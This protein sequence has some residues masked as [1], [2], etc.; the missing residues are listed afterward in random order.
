MRRLVQLL[1]ALAL[2]VTSLPLGGVTPAAAEDFSIQGG[3][4][5]TQTGGG[6]GKG[7]AITDE[8][9]VRFWSEFR[10]LGGV[11]AVGYPISR[12]FQWDGFTVQ[13]MQ[14]VVFQWR[15]E[16]GQVYFINTFDLLS[17]AGKDEWLT[18]V[19]QTPPPLPADFDA[20]KDWP[21][22]VAARLALLDENP[23]IRQKYFSVVGDAVTMNG[24]PT[25][26]VT[27]MGNNLTLRAQRVVFQQWKEHVPWARAGEVTVALGGSIAAEAG[28]LPQD[29]LAAE[30]APP[31]LSG[32][33][34]L[35]A[36]PAPPPSNVQL[37]GLGY[38]MQVD[39]NADY[40]R[41]LGLTRQAGFGWV[42]VQARWEDLEAQP[43]NV[44][45]EFF[46]RIIGGA[47]AAGVKL[48]LSV[49]TA[50]M[51]SRPPGSDHNVPGPPA[52]PQ[53]FANFVGGIAARYPG[54]VGGYEIWNEQNLAREWGGNGRQNAAEYVRMLQASYRAI[55]AV[56][57]AAAVV[58]GAL[59]PAGNVNLGEG[60]LAVDDVE[61]F[62]QMYDAGMK[63]Y[64]DAV[65]AHPSG[66][67]NAPDLNPLDPAVLARPGSFRS[68]RSFYFRNFE[69]YREIM[70]RWGDGNKQIWIT[71]FGWAAG[72]NPA[73]EYAYA[74][75]NSEE[76]QANYL[77][78]AFQIARE[79]GYIG[80]MFVWN[81]NFAPGAD[82][83]DVQGKRVFGILN[84][85]WSPRAAYH[86]LAAMPK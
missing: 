8:G 61:Y 23:A 48:L 73:P 71:E 69:R 66:F 17:Q 59:T 26:R 67:N 18:A 53:T 55:K 40:G 83:G 62:A 47:E 78:R 85:D 39:P 13:A 44:N 37:G 16:A 80:P 64:F 38:G 22:I 72:P 21:A 32:P 41:A 12:R 5:F 84:S 36:P 24:L 50:P 75:D 27:D 30:D 60:L 29:A 79:R 74:A 54:R 7:Y 65:G 33:A 34:P 11:Q 45:W 58:V 10:R 42:K 28:L 35:S 68:H 1:V 20:G 6:G 63:G 49:V 51:W 3:H 25:S 57:P 2:V 4:F 14:R 82:P 31:P 15:P 77:V 52:D 70:L 43:G 81:L 19:R 86:A 76:D 9:G 46:D 56:D